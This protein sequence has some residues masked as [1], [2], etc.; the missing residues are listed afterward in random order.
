MAAFSDSESSSGNSIQAGTLNLDFDGSTSFSFS[1]TLKPKG[2]TSDS[3]T[4]VS[5]GSLDGSLDVDVSYTEADS[6]KG[7]EGNAQAFAERLEVESLTYGEK[8]IRDQIDSESTPTLHELA[9]NEQT[10]GESTGNDLINL[11]DPG[12]PSDGGTKF[13]IKFRLKDVKNKYQGDGVS[14]T[15]HFHLNQ[16]DS[17]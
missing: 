10:D 3:V 14:V 1:G 9:N 4:L 16:N 15:F 5:D 13:F 6:N 8:D 12:D 2:T 17:Q 7:K 11:D